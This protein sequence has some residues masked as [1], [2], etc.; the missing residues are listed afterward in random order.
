MRE[1]E[2]HKEEQVNVLK[3]AMSAGMVNIIN[4]LTSQTEVLKVKKCYFDICP[5]II[6]QAQAMKEQAQLREEMAYQYKIGNYEVYVP[7][8][9]TNKLLG[10]I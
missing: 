2:K 5:S 1:R 7:T 9:H 4:L 3:R 10:H 6:V 8:G